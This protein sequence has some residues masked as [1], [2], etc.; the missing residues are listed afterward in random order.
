MGSSVYHRAQDFVPLSR[1]TP[2]H[3]LPVSARS[4][5]PA[6]TE[7]E[8]VSEPSVQLGEVRQFA[9]GGREFVMVVAT[10]GIFGVDDLGAK[11]LAFL[12]A[13]NAPAAT[14][15]EQ[16]TGARPITFPKVYSAFEGQHSREQIRGALSELGRMGAIRLRGVPGDRPIATVPKHPPLPFP[17]KSLVLNVANDCNLGCSYCFAAQGDYGAPRQMMD[18]TTARRSVDFLLQ[19]SGDSD[20]VTLVFFGGEPLMNL[21]LIRRLVVYANEAGDKA[22][23]KVEFS[24]TTNAT[25]LTP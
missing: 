3:A 11:I 19:N 25:Y 20:S 5:P 7:E 14:V 1:L 12:R 9:A 2:K 22:G 8:P 4:A 21:P 18:E 17:Q 15:G 6:Q 13:E 16:A 24:V 10:T 23:K